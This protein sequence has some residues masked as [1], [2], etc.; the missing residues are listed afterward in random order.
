[1]KPHRWRSEHHARRAPVTVDEDHHSAA[2]LIIG[3]NPGVLRTRRR[4]P[5][6]VRPDPVALPHPVSADPDRHGVRS[7]GRRL[8][9]HRRR[10]PG[11]RDRR[12]L[13]DRRLDVDTDN[14]RRRRWH[15][16]FD[17]PD[18][19]LDRRRR[20]PDGARRQKKHGRQQQISHD[21]PL[22]MQIEG[23][24]HRLWMC[25]IDSRSRLM[26]RS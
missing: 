19:G 14:R 12:R 8:D 21:S 1:V 2:V 5:V 3:M 10:G 20:D 16:E 4:H 6:S 18:V 24:T 23:E 26:N 15:V 11:H 25:G 7:R 17:R 13:G 9:Q 22:E